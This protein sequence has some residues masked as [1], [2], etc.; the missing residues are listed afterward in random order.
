M[1]L[2]DPGSSSSSGIS[3]EQAQP[4]S[5]ESPLWSLTAASGR[6]YV[7]K[8]KA[9]GLVFDVMN[10]TKAVGPYVVLETANGSSH[11]TWV[12]K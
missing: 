4:A 5:D 9:T 8:N 2:T 11:Q 10:G 6:G 7:I 3:L 12:L 1:F